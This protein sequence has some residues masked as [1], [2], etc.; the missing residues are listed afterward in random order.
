LT[1]FEKILPQPVE[2][3][4]AGQLRAAILSGQLELGAH[5][6]EADLA[7]Q[8]A[9]SRIPVREALRLLE[10]E[11]LVTRRPNHG[12]FVIT[13]QDQ[14]VHEVFSLRAHLENMALEWATPLLVGA[15]FAALRALVA[16][17]SEAICAGDYDRLAGLD[18]QF[19]QH[20]C[21]RAGHARLLKAWSEQHT[22]CQILLNH[23]FRRLPDAAPDTVLTDH[24]ALLQAL[25]AR[26]VPAAQRLTLEISQRVAQECIAIL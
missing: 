19:H 25:E 15:D 13:F 5:L 4:I 10:Q 1:A 24:A 21:T 7:A 23:R 14:D 8:M 12:C 17:Q 11:G 2:K 18:I 3:T 16:A 20:I 26:D 9:V 6:P 22:Q